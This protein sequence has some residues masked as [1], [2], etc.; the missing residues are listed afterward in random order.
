MQM[1]IAG[2]YNWTTRP[3]RSHEKVHFWVD[4][5]NQVQRIDVCFWHLPSLVPELGW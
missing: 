2:K 4:E 3:I 1:S 5:W